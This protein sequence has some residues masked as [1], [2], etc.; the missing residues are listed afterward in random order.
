[1][2]FV[3]LLLLLFGSAGDLTA[4]CET[5]Y[6]AVQGCSARDAHL[7]KCKQSYLDKLV[8][9]GATYT[10]CL[11]TCTQDDS[12][13]RSECRE[14][15]SKVHPAATAGASAVYALC[16]SRTPECV[17][18]CVMDPSHPRWWCPPWPDCPYTDS[19]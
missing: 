18:D 4:Q 11:A 16:R 15:C 9:I 2:T 3:T 13:E 14:N 19:N 5:G 7:K 1:M 17:T 8:T 10:G 12:S 6:K